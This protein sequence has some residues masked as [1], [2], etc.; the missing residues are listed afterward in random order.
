MEGD[1]GVPLSIELLQCLVQLADQLHRL[2][3]R[4]L[5]AASDLL[6]DWNRLVGQSGGESYRTTRRERPVLAA[7]QVGAEVEADR[8]GLLDRVDFL[9]GPTLVT[10]HYL[11]LDKTRLL[12]HLQVFHHSLLADI[13]VLRQLQWVVRLPH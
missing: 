3:D 1:E 8:E 13:E 5:P 2:R 9:R 4:Y 7:E 12:K 11:R 6:G 10:L